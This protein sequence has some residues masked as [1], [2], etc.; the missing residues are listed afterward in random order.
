MLTLTFSVPSMA[1]LIASCHH[2]IFKILLQSPIANLHLHYVVSSV[3]LHQR[4]AASFKKPL[5]PLSPPH[6][7]THVGLARTIYMRCTYGIFG[8]EITKYTV[9][10]YVYIR[11]WP[12]LH[13]CRLPPT[14][15]PQSMSYRGPSCLWVVPYT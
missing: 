8:L 5:F 13:T 10:I 2:S 3:R 14:N 1:S 4:C 12:I 9:Y 15:Q 6:K 7:P 11:F